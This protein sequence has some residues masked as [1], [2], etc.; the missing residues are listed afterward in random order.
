MPVKNEHKF[1]GILL[2]EKISF[3]PHIKLLKRKCIGAINILK[4]LSHH[5]YGADKMLPLRIYNS[6]VK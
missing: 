1:L 6:L 5:Y 3:I 4:V 2:D